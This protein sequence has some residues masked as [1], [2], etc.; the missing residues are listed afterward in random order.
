MVQLKNMLPFLSGIAF[1]FYLLPFFIKDTGS[2]MLVL[3]ILLPVICLICSLIYGMLK[4]FTFF[5]PIAVS[6]LFLPSI[7]IFYNET[8]WIYIIVFGLIAL[9][10]SLLGAP[11]SKY[12]K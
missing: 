10:G 3:L 2:A 4:P 12:Q 5:Y 9:I 8:A 6:L 11:F 7:F 1:S